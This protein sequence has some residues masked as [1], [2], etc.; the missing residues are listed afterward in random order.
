[1]CIGGRLGLDLLL[2]DEPSV[3][4]LFGET[5]GCLLVEIAPEKAAQFKNELAGLAFKKLGL[6]T[7][8][9]GLRIHSG[10][11]LLMNAPVEQIIRAWQA[12]N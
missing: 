9:A 2:P 8:Q 1:M 5:N 4:G 10:A 3:V 12:P 7:R 11:H 6:V